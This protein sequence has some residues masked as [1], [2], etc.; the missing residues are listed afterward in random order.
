[1][2]ITLFQRTTK[3]SEQFLDELLVRITDPVCVI[4]LL[5]F[6]YAHKA[7]MERCRVFK[8]DQ[9]LSAVKQRLADRFRAICQTNQAAIDTADARM[10]VENE[11]TAHHAKAMT[12]RFAE[13]ATSL[14][15][16]MIDE[17]SDLMTPELHMV[18]ATVIDLLERTS[19][20]LS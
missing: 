10:F 4:L 13:F 16:L 8:I 9:R 19:R 3:F 18:A 11:A 5:R 15:V 20:E 12:R 17:I 14:S 7:E 6:A 2:T 1:V